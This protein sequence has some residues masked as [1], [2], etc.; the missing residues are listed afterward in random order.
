LREL[1][2]RFWDINKKRWCG[3]AAHL[4]KVY[5]GINK[6]DMHLNYITE[7]FTGLKDKNGI[8][9]YEG[10]KYL[11]STGETGVITFEN[12]CFNCYCENNVFVLCSM[13]EDIEIIGNIHEK[14]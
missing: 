6:E 13:N 2:F 12:G 14:V 11:H 1:K 8:D 4:H 10:D 7:Q 3:K 5:Y 9:I